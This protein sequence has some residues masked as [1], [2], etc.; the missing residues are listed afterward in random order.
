MFRII[1]FIIFKLNNHNLDQSTALFKA[2]C[3][4]NLSLILCNV[5][6]I[7]ASSANN[8]ISA[9]SAQTLGRSLI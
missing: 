8:D 6:E 3:S 5:L 7:F 4:N 1:N 9:Y 2:L